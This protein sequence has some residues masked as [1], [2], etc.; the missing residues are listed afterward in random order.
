M[1]QSLNAGPA[2]NISGFPARGMN[3]TGHV[4]GEQYFVGRGG[5][6]RRLRGN[7]MNLK[8][9]RYNRG[10][11]GEVSEWLIEHAWKACVR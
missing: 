6:R 10:F 8:P 1:Q 3:Y 11:S 9:S 4:E 5:T 7:L 2:L